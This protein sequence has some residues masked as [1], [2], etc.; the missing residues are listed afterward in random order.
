MFAA[1]KCD[2]YATF[3][4]YLASCD[5]VAGMY[6]GGG[7]DCV[8]KPTCEEAQQCIT[9]AMLTG[10]PYRGP[11]T[12]CTDP[13]DANL[14][15][16]V[17]PV[18]FE[19]SYGRNDRRFSDSPSSRERPIEVCGMPA[20]LEYLTRVTCNGGSRPFASR[21]AADESRVGNVGTGGRCNRIVDRY[22]VRCPEKAY[23]VFID[24]YRCPTH[25]PVASTAEPPPVPTTRGSVQDSAIT[26]A[27]PPVRPGT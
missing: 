4:P 3:G 10:A 17:S 6:V 26:L 23:D 18:D 11:T 27:L 21:R 8:N 5:A 9:Q 19:A 7:Q 24:A 16:G 15:A 2:P 13:T 20:E 25:A 12:A 1:Q 22:A 14:P